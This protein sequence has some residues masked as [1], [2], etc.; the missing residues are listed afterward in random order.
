V[1]A[2]GTTVV[3][4]LETAARVSGPVPS[5]SAW[6]AGPAARAAVS[7]SAGWTEH[8]VT[9]EPGS[10]PLAV[11]G[12]ITGLHEPRSSHLRMLA[13]FAGPDLLSR[14]YAAAIEHGYLWHEFGDLHLL[15]P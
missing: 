11:D 9:P 10:R 12:L 8:I 3:R 14:C 7:P 15:L 4:A 13:A 2:L 5:P 6:P 1:V